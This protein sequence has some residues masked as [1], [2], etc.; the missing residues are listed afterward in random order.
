MCENFPVCWLCENGNPV[1]IRN[2]YVRKSTPSCCVCSAEDDG[3]LCGRV[4]NFLAAQ[5]LYR[6]LRRCCAWRSRC[7]PL[8][9][10]VGPIA[11]SRSTL[12]VL[13][14]PNSCVRACPTTNRGKCWG[15]PVR[16]RA[17]SLSI[18]LVRSQDALWRPPLPK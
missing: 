14:S 17:R 2:R 5:R 7:V 11:P 1:K 12:S 4:C 8:A 13:S 6:C 15:A 3:A 16:E 9:H 10:A 18:S